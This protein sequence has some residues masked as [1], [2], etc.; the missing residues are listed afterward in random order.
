MGCISKGKDLIFVR[1]LHGNS[2]VIGNQLLNTTVNFYVIKQ[3]IKYDHSKQGKEKWRAIFNK[4]LP[5]V[6]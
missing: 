3:E 6:L 4:R 2:S 1:A 5:A